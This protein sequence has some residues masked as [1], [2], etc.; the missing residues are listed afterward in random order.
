MPR[1]PRYAAFLR[2]VSPQNASM[3]ALKACLEAGGFKN[4]KTLLSSG[5]VVFDSR[6]T[7]LTALER[8]IEALLGEGLGN[9][10][11]TIIR[12]SDDLRALLDSD[13]YQDFRL[14][15]GTKRVVTFL[16]QPPTTRLKL[17][18]EFQDAR[19]LCVRGTE[20]FSAYIPGPQGPVFMGLI[21]KTFG[22]DITTRTWDTVRKVEMAARAARK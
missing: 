1:M 12:G 8:K 4:V 7:S 10:F 11:P 9:P 22:K 18:L 20:A 3:P 14:A 5:N 2:G 21:E 16:R 19:I 17:P 13:P 15:P 6:A